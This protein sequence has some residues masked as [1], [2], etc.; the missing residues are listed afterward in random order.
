[1]LSAF[2]HITLYPTKQ[3]KPEN[4]CTF[5]ISNNK[6]LI[7][8]NLK[9]V[10]PFGE[11]FDVFSLSGFEIQSDFDHKIS[12]IKL[13]SARALKH[14]LNEK[15]LIHVQVT[16]PISKFNAQSFETYFNLVR[17]FCS[18]YVCLVYFILIPE[19]VN[20]TREIIFEYET[21]SAKEV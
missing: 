16:A 14:H 6:S 10:G 17:V 5:T 7:S 8:E 2:S 9:V 18:M 1:M 11:K 19:S 15:N 20:C 21:N 4:F 3:S 13:Y 12:K